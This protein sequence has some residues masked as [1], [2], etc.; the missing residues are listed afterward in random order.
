MQSIQVVILI[1]NQKFK[2]SI[3]VGSITPSSVTAL[4]SS[5]TN[6]SETIELKELVK[7]RFSAKPIR[8]LHLLNSTLMR[9]DNRPNSTAFD[10]IVILVQVHY[11]PDYFSAFVDSL[12]HVKYIEHTLVIF[13]HDFYDDR[14][15]AIVDAI[16][17]CATLQIFYPFSIQLYPN[18]FPGTDPNDCPRETPKNLYYLWLYQWIRQF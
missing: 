13:S 10:F 16:D 2:I 9:S 17:F 14:I 12:R 4:N 11:R 18:E 7:K 8:S 5:Q 1:I 3:I 6:K 15:N